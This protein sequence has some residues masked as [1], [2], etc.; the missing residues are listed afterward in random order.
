MASSL[1]PKK[2]AKKSVSVSKIDL[3]SG[4]FLYQL[5]ADLHTSKQAQAFVK[6][7]FTT[8]EQEAFVKRLS[9]AQ[10]LTQ[11]RSYEQI[12]KELGVSSATIS[13]VAEQLTSDGF[14]I[15]L[16]KMQIDTWARSTAAKIAGWL[17]LR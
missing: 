7:F 14:Q 6:D 16:K 11:G 12:R 8:S 13:T 5:I 3:P 10:L 9:V 17:H 2:V 4:E 15:A 1:H